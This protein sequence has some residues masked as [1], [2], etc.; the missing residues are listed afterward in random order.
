MIFLSAQRQCLLNRK[1]YS[2]FHQRFPPV[3]SPQTPIHFKIPKLLFPVPIPL[4]RKLK[5]SEWRPKVS[6]SPA[7]IPLCPMV[8]SKSFL[9]RRQE[10]NIDIWQL[11]PRW[12]LHGLM[13]EELLQRLAG[14]S[15]ALRRTPPRCLRGTFLV[16]DVV[17]LRDAERSQGAR[18]TLQTRV[19]E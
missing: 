1:A 7:P 19:F 3:G 9:Q 4:S 11:L 17:G 15:F 10:P 2:S 14:L 13:T 5:T 12:R 6:I 18:S 16:C 8:S